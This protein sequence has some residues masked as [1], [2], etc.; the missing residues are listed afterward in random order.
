MNKLEQKF[1]M[2]VGLPGSGKTTYIN[3]IKENKV[4]LSSDKIREELYGDEST[5]GNSNEVFELLHKRMVEKLSKGES[6]VYDATNLSRRKRKH[7][8]SLINKF[9]C[10]KIVVYM[11]IDINTIK[12]RNRARLR[13]V[14]ESVIERMYKHL[15]VPQYTENW[16]KIVIESNNRCELE[17]SQDINELEFNTG[18]KQLIKDIDIEKYILDKPQNNK[19]HS[20]SIDR[21]IYKV[22]QYVKEN[23]FGTFKEEMLWAAI[24]HDVGKEICRETKE[25]LYDSFIGHEN[26]SAQI[27]FDRLYRLGYE[28]EYILKVVEIVQ[29]HMLYINEEKLKKDKRQKNADMFKIKMMEFFRVADKLGH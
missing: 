26:V 15:Q 2:M 22:Y 16:D 18:Y 12:K 14:D 8:I 7:V 25:N 28:K 27:A 29:N 6:V 5:Q 3:N 10:E 19:Y 23:Y 11:N 20:F 9:K 17:T 24:L 1:I 13:V 4:I 21:H